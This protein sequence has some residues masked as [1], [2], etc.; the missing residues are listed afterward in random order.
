MFTR[1]SVV[2][3]NKLKSL[4]ISK[5]DLKLVQK[6]FFVK[7]TRIF[8]ETING[9]SVFQVKYL[10]KADLSSNLISFVEEGTFRNLVHLKTLDLSNNKCAQI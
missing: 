1:L 6:D 7:V 2:E 4:D 10:E 8:Q 5:N 3:D 9:Y